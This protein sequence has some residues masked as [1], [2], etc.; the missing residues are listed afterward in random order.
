MSAVEQTFDVVVLGAGSAGETLAGELAARGCPW[1]S[2][3]RGSSGRVPLPGLRAE[4]D[5]CSWPRPRGVDWT[6]AVRRRDEAAEHRDDSV[7][8]GGWSSRG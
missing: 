6:V 8:C 5:V 4:Q 3:S 7:R 2:S 1:P